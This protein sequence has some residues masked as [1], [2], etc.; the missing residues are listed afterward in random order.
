M[1]SSA[2]T[3]RHSHAVSCEGYFSVSPT[4]RAVQNSFFFMVARA[5]YSLRPLYHA[6]SPRSPDNHSLRPTPPL[7]F[8]VFPALEPEAGWFYKLSPPRLIHTLVSDTAREI[9]CLI[10]H[11]RASQRASPF[12]Q[13]QISCPISW[14]KRLLLQPMPC[15]S[16]LHAH[17]PEDHSLRLER[18]FLTACGD[19]AAAFHINLQGDSAHPALLTGHQNFFHPPQIPATVSWPLSPSGKNAY[20]GKQE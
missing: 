18:L 8:L 2:S 6:R 17:G 19:T 3:H 16:R 12:P 14:R 13:V 20:I 4:P 10:I 15:P 9:F 7:P 1:Y 5:R 11:S